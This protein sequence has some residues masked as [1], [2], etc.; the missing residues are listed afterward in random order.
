[1]RLF[2]AIKAAKDMTKNLYTPRSCVTPRPGLL[3][4]LRTG[5]SL[6]QA[7]APHGMGQGDWP[8]QTQVGGT[9]Q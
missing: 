1:M 8:P 5:G 4:T 6:R 2:Q 9:G 3:G 7:A